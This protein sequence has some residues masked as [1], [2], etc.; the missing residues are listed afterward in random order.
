MSPWRKAFWTSYGIALRRSRTDTRAR[1]I[2]FRISVLFLAIAA[3][4]LLWLLPLRSEEGI[5]L[6][7]FNGGVLGLAIIMRLLL[8]RSN[9]RR[10]EMLSFSLTEPGGRTLPRRG[11]VSDSVRTY[12]TERALTIGSLVSRAASE[13]FI[14]HN[15]LAPGLTVITRQQQNALLR[16]AGLWISSNRPNWHSRPQRTDNGPRNRLTSSTGVNSCA[17]FGGSSEST[18]N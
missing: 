2:V 12:L 15:E 16:R 17:S 7:A 9:R 13:I 10:T 1:L 8:L 11:E 3:N 4:V 5:W 18:P 14:R 6:F